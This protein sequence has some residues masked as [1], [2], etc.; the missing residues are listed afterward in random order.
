MTHD[1]TINFASSLSKEDRVK[2]KQKVFKE[3][4]HISYEEGQGIVTK[5]WWA[6]DALAFTI[7]T[8]SNR[9]IDV[10]PELGDSIEKL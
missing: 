2:W 8:D 9:N 5:T 3:G 4:K 7:L 10:I 1:E 6:M